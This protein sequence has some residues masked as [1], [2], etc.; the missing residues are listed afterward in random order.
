MNAD[1]ITIDNAIGKYDLYMWLD[2][3]NDQELKDLL[4]NVTTFSSV[5]FYNLSDEKT[6]IL[7]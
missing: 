1:E 7:Y 2:Y 3:F 5:K 6:H 4:K